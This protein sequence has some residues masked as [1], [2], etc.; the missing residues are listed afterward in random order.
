MSMYA[1]I[2]LEEERKNSMTKWTVAD[3]PL[4][5]GKL[6]V[7]TGANSGI[8]WKTALELAR[9]G[10]E[11]ILTGRDKGKGQ[12]AF[13]R[14]RPQVPAGRGPFGHPAL[15]VPGCGRALSA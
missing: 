2:Y 1:L 3:I 10:A 12:G 11:G 7:V 9:G 15:A 8:G 4:Q 6:A 13:G 14:I 5:R